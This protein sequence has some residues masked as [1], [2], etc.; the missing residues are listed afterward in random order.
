M[1][2]DNDEYESK[3]PQCKDK[4]NKDKIPKNCCIPVN[5]ILSEVTEQV[6]LISSIRSIN[7][8]GLD[9]R[10]IGLTLKIT[11]FIS[12]IFISNGIPTEIVY[13]VNYIKCPVEKCIRKCNLTLAIRDFA[14]SV[15]NA[16][17]QGI[18]I[19]NGSVVTCNP[20]HYNR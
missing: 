4:S 14:F 10:L 20:E 15:T 3:V 18:L 6:G 13:N 19:I 12:A 1:Y 7:T 11:G 2:N 17:L 5:L 9:I 16:G 8:D